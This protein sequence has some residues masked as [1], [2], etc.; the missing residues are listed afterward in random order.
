MQW[1]LSV[2]QCV[3][4]VQKWQPT[5]ERMPA[6]H[7]PASADVRRGTSDDWPVPSVRPAVPCTWQAGRESRRTAH[8]AALQHWP[9]DVPSSPSRDIHGCRRSMPTL[10]PL[11]VC[12]QQWKQAYQC[13]DSWGVGWVRKAEQIVCRMSD[14]RG[15]HRRVPRDGA[16]GSTDVRRFYCS[17]CTHMAWPVGWS[18]R[19]MHARSAAAW[20]W[21]SCHSHGTDAASAERTSCRRP[22]AFV[23][24]KHRSWCN[25]VASTSAANWR[26][27]HRRY[28]SVTAAKPF[29]QWISQNCCQPTRQ[30]R[31]RK[32]RRPQHSRQHADAFA[33]V[34]WVKRSVQTACCTQDRSMLGRR[35][36]SPCDCWGDATSQTDDRIHNTCTVSRRGEIESVA[37]NHTAA[38][39]QGET[40]LW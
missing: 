22:V 24:N 10:D 35:C 12:T 17:R 28:N 1:Q 30:R 20:W 19:R 29:H 27:C 37:L 33:C 32:N 4:V 5:T 9:V 11:A 36:V 23:W 26:S 21:T 40:T 39:T 34:A 3:P 6:G 38:N 18:V 14:R 7:H 25:D 16:W 15:P 13:D 2:G 8:L 31:R